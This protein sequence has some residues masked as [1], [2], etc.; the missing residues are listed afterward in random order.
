MIRVLCAAIVLAALVDAVAA[1]PGISA[2]KAILTDAASGRVLFERDAD[3]TSLIASTTKIMT[4][5]I[6]CENCDLSQVVQIP[7]E[8]VGVARS[9]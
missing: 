5:L 6:V 3:T 4:A 2:Q 7:K 1:A 8:A 9:A